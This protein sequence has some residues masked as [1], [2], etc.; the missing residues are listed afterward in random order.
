MGYSGAGGKLFHEKTRSKKSRDTVPLR[1]NVKS[2]P[3]ELDGAQ[4]IVFSPQSSELFKKV[5]AFTLSNDSAPPPPPSPPPLVRKLDRRR[6][7]RL[8]K[9]DN[10]LTGEAGGGGGEG[11]K[12][13][14]SYDPILARI[15]RFYPRVITERTQ[16]SIL[17]MSCFLYMKGRSQR[18]V[19]QPGGADSVLFLS[20][21]T[22]VSWSDCTVFA[23]QVRVP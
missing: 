14:K 15:S 8:R 20:T 17:Y 23:L 4:Q 16:R 22:T 13:A 1:V 2:F 11:A 10:L 5:Q 12:G 7:E 18:L 19:R 21:S 3:N 9:R 6:T